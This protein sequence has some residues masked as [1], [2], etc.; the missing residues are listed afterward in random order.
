LK[1][2]L[3]A[4]NVEHK[5]HVD[6]LGSKISMTSQTL[7]RE[8]GQKKKVQEFFDEEKKKF[9]SLSLAKDK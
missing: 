8:A 7:I 1:I 3:A 5:E 6:S 9:H 2:K 4:I